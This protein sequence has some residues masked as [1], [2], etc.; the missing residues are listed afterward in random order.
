MRISKHCVGKR[1]ENE[2]RNIIVIIFWSDSSGEVFSDWS[3]TSQ[4]GSGCVET[5][6]GFPQ[7]RSQ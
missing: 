6:Q 7:A 5:E 3:D 2:I 4:A 1:Y